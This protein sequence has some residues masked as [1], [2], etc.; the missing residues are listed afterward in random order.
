MAAN[1]DALAN[2]FLGLG[3]KT[4]L[5]LLGLMADEPVSV[6]HLVEVTGDSQPKVSR[7]LAYLRNA[8]L[9]ETTRDGKWIY[10]GVASLDDPAAES[11]FRCVVDEL[12]GHSTPKPKPQKRTVR[13]LA[14]G[15][16]PEAEPQPE[17][18][19][20]EYFYETQPES[21]SEPEWTH[22]SQEPQEELDVFLL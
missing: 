5:R 17:P 1:Y 18:V 11:V 15:P 12:S 20:E 14:P 10:Y 9:V 19:H 4:R 16:I 8:G 6:G 7:H 2:L 21:A 13:R 22:P 3:D